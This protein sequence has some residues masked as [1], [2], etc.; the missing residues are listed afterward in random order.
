M[1]RLDILSEP[2]P[3]QPG[4]ALI[5]L[6][7]GHHHLDLVRAARPQDAAGDRQHCRLRL[8]LP[9]ARSS[10]VFFAIRAFCS[11]LMRSP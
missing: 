11:A 2:P 3:D 1:T 9:G 4:A 8:G 7:P 5:A 6:G 10:A